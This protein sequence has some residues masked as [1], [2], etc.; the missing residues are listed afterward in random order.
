[1]KMKLYEPTYTKY[2]IPYWQAPKSIVAG[3]IFFIVC[4][5]E[6]HVLKIALSPQEKEK[7]KLGCLGANLSRSRL[8]STV[9]RD[10][11]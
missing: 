9:Q 10:Q 11:V 7:D 2:L 5:L 1:M 3:I 6:K 4:R 8:L